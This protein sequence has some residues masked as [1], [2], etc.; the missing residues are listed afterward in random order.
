MI[1]PGVYDPPRYGFR[2]LGW[3]ALVLAL[4][5]AFMGVLH[6][7][8]EYK[9]TLG[10]NALDC[11]GPAQTYLFAFPT[12]LIYGLGLILNALR[13]PRRVN[14]VAAMLCLGICI[15]TGFNIA[16]ADAEQRRQAPFCG[17]NRQ[18]T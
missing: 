6:D 11:D 16:R 8:N 15:A 1:V 4:P 12:L 9:A 18:A 5:I 10:I 17:W 3:G 14:I 2:I 13:W 7:P